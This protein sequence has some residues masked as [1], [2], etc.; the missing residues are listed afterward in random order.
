M[1][2]R[3]FV[4]APGY[5]ALCSSLLAGFLIVAVGGFLDSANQPL[6]DPDWMFWLLAVALVSLLTRAPFVG[7][8]I[9]GERITHRTWVRSRTW[10]IKDI[11]DVGVSQY[12]GLL[13]RAF[14][15]RRYRMIVLMKSDGDVIDVPELSGKARRVDGLRRALRAALTHI[16]A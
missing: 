6:L 15:S 12:S 16:D 8:V 7:V 10:S 13:N 4:R 11:A 1:S 14:E 3:Q 9:C 5:I 2:K